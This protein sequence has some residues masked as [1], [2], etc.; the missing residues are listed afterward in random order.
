[1][2][3]TLAAI[4]S[5]AEPA[6]SVEV[7]DPSGLHTTYTLD[8]NGRV[9]NVLRKGVEV[10]K[11]D[12]P[13]PTDLSESYA[14]LDDGRIS[15]LTRADG[16]RATYT[17]PPPG[18]ERLAYRIPSITEI[19]KG[20]DGSI[21]RSFG[22]QGDG[23]VAS[24]TDP[25]GRVI[26]P[27]VPEAGVSV[28]SSTS[29]GLSG[30]TDYD[31]F[32]R[33]AKAAGGAGTT[34]TTLYDGD[35]LGR[36]GGG[37]PSEVVQGEPGKAAGKYVAAT[38]DPDER[39]NPRT[40]RESSG[41]VT[42][43]EYDEWDRPVH[44]S[45]GRGGE[46]ESPG[47]VYRGFDTAGRLV[48]EVRSQ[49][50]VGYV[51]TTWEYNDRDQVTRI[52]RDRI[53]GATPFAAPDAT[54]TTTFT[55]A[56]LSGFLVAVSTDQG[57]TTTY[58][59]EKAGRLAAV[60]P[61]GSGTRLFGYDEM[62]RP[63]FE[64]DG[65]RGTWKGTYDSFGRLGTEILPGGGVVTRTF[66]KAGGL[67]TAKLDGEGTTLSEIANADVTSWGALKS[68]ERRM[69]ADRSLLVSRTLDAEGR[70]TEQK[71]DE[72]VDLR[73]AFA[74]PAGR[75][76][77]VG[78]AVNALTLD[79]GGAAA[80][81]P[82]VMTYSAVVDPA[83]PSLTT[84]VSTLRHDALGRVVEDKRDDGTVRTALYDEES[85][86]VET[87][88]GA[89]ATRFGWDSR[90]SLVQLLRPDGQGATSL[91]YD[92]DGRLT[93]KK[94]DAGGT[95][96]EATYDYYPPG[97]N[98]AG[99]LRTFSR[100]GGPTLAV[101]EYYPDDMPRVEALSDGSTVALEYDDA[102]RV[103]KTT[104]T[105]GSS[106]PGGA[107]YTWDA[108]SRLTGASRLKANGIDVDPAAA[109][110]PGAYDFAG[111]PHAET[112][113]SRPA[114]TRDYDLLGGV[115]FL[116]L[117]LGVGAARP[118]SYA[119]TYEPLTH[120]LASVT[121]TGDA[122]PA[123]DLLPDLLGASWA[124]AGDDRVL[125]V[126]SNGPLHAAH[127]FGYVGGPGGPD[128]AAPGAARWKLGTLSVGTDPGAKNFLPFG[129]AAAPGS[130]AWGQFEYGYDSVSRDATKLGR[131]ITTLGLAAGSV[132]SNQGWAYG[133]D[134]A[135]R[136]TSAYPGPGS[137]TG[138]DAVA[139]RRRLRAL[140]VRVRIGRPA[141]EGNA[142]DRRARR[143][144]R[145]RQ[146]TG[147]P[148]RARSIPTFRL[149]ERSLSSPT[150]ASSVASPTTASPSR[151]TTTA[152]SP[153]PSSRTAA[154]SKTANPRARPA[155]RATRARPTPATSS[156]SRTTPSRVS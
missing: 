23:L 43:I 104:V 71:S 155:R 18:P 111:R 39:G 131:A 134:A 145:H 21:T 147:G 114:L 4:P 99:L 55:Y 151:G 122:P 135:R 77:S 64:F 75:A 5:T 7:L 83:K 93:A 63:T 45:F 53:A 57:T 38:F 69:T 119:R 44:E 85:R 61:D 142:R 19:G 48:K 82:K 107:L 109:V 90:G 47:D 106:I 108:A 91:G 116:G 37:F 102:N 123:G 34:V 72:H 50:N 117:P 24:I 153:R 49:L 128:P 80:A 100:T 101:K 130:S 60:T 33:P 35:A 73:V 20:A 58:R 98:F 16:T 74:D 92:H 154:P 141:H 76:T 88:D 25:E 67:K 148:T 46:Q 22:Y 14:Y 126:T 120:R 31:A 149:P 140:Q 125:G 27:G 137:V 133:L 54:S 89:A 105:G 152:G 139:G 87:A 97:G 144:L 127:R 13:A 81:W 52:T 42:M 51:T 136:L 86:P 32:G 79:Y 40:I 17:P 110:V 68:L 84:L 29:D 59:F 6:Q 138:A 62:G 95:S 26:D 1:M 118:F 124:W 96:Y 2:T 132:L 9:T 3:W 146:R 156:S 129:D 115:T 11:G 8:A 30:T 121:G 103:T 66:D 12:A 113:G 10:S 94:T 36:K 78:D 56:P 70:L 143:W 112:V 15:S 28:P 41:A 65:D 150:T